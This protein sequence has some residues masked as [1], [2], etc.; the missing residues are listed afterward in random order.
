[1]IKDYKKFETEMMKKYPYINEFTF[2]AD[3]DNDKPLHICWLKFPYKANTSGTGYFH[4][5]SEYEFNKNITD[6]ELLNLN[7]IEKNDATPEN[8]GLDISMDKFKIMLINRK[9][10]LLL[11]D[12]LYAMYS[13]TRVFI[14]KKEVF[15]ELIMEC[16]CED[17][18]LE[19]LKKKI[20]YDF[21]YM[22]QNK[23]YFAIEM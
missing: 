9:Q 20:A 7:D 19:F 13:K 10:N 14:Y 5:D 21:G 12:Y 1:M 6:V 23:W 4:F 11:L 15:G 18:P 3:Y 2:E 17:I 8:Y 22:E 16:N